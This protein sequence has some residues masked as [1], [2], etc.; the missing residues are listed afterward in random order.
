MPEENA[1]R[2]EVNEALT[3]SPPQPAHEVP[4]DA[5]SGRRQRRRRRSSSESKEPEVRVPQRPAWEVWVAALLVLALCFLGGGRSVLARA[6][7]MG[8]I[9]VLI[10]LAPPTFRAP[11]SLLLT[12]FAVVLGPLVACLPSHMLELDSV[13]RANLRENW[14][15]SLP[16]SATA[17][18]WVTFE[19]W[20]VHATGCAW[21]LWCLGRGTTEDDRR[22]LLRLL[23]SGIVALAVLTLLQE[24]G[25]LHIPFWRFH[26]DAGNTYGPFVNRNHTSGLFAIGSVLCAACA[27]DA[28]RR[29]S[30]QWAPFLLGIVPL[31]LA[32]IANTS[33]AGLLLFFSG[34]TV[35]LS[36]AAVRKGLFKKAAIVATIVVMGFALMSITGSKVFQRLAKPADDADAVPWARDGRIGI[37]ADSIL[38][39]SHSPWAGVGLG[40]FA[41]RYPLA[42][43]LGNSF[44]R[45]AHPESDVIWLLA[46][47]GII[48]LAPMLVG[49]ILIF[50]RT[51]P[52]FSTRSNRSSD[53]QDRRLRNA[54]AIG[55]ALGLL[56]SVVDVPLH[57]MALMITVGLM[58][59]VCVRQSRVAETPGRAHSLAFR[60][61]GA[62]LL[63][64]SVPM[65]LIAGGRP[66]LPGTSSAALL[67]KRSLELSALGRDADAL[68]ALNKAIEM[69]PLDWSFYFLRAQTHLR[70]NRSYSAA[71]EDFG[72]ARTLEPNYAKPCFEE[73][74]IW[75]AYEPRLAVPAW[76]EFLARNPVNKP[77]HYQAMLMDTSRIPGMHEQLRTLATSADLQLIYLQYSQGDFKTTLSSMLANS[78]ILDGLDPEDRTR[79]LRLW[80]ERGDRDA[81]RAFL[82]KNALLHVDGWQL[83]AEERARVGEF[84]SAYELA[85]KFI[86]I[87]TSPTAAGIENI[88]QLEKNFLFNQTDPRRGVDLYFAQK[89]R[90]QLNEALGTLEKISVLPNAP[91]YLKYEMASIHALKQDHRTAWEL[92]H[93]Y[94][95]KA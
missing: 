80:Q 22:G 94:Y 86:P 75:L 48:T 47:G 59:G 24:R 81:L 92:L 51:G 20:L 10:L 54:L 37:Y 42:S 46:E 7:G 18:P 72:R 90:G 93:A 41:D 45:F 2:E 14:G 50:R 17:Q 79:F 62:A 83:L 49:A 23:A 88:A 36:T 67:S 39:A 64:A 68:E 28:Y 70:L 32:I 29:R 95:T 5:E 65:F 3:A 19:A 38:M 71:L 60:L 16:D 6:L 61:G 12:F 57:G 63:A 43:T 34:L 35:W 44:A 52:W 76:R 55:A 87:P 66:A 73:G 91:G 85:V 27:L 82:E 11:K 78:N 26:R 40:N 33:R 4:G 21:V 25:L 58:A 77:D 8:L 89:A 53:R 84:Q 56:H 31:F 69:K 1:I 9:G 74:R 13:W 15:I 30:R